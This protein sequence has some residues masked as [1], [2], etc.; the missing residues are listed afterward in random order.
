MKAFA[1]LALIFISSYSFAQN[2]LEGHSYGGCVVYHPLGHKIT[3]GSWVGDC[4]TGSAQGY[5]WFTYYFADNSAHSDYMEYKDGKPVNPY[6]FNSDP[7]NGNRILKTHSDFSRTVVKDCGQKPETA[8]AAIVMSAYE[9]LGDW[10]RINQKIKGSYNGPQTFPGIKR[11]FTSSG[12]ITP[13]NANFLIGSEGTKVSCD[14]KTLTD[15]INAGSKRFKINSSDPCE[16]QIE[17]GRSNYNYLTTLELSCPASNVSFRIARNNCHT[18]INNAVA[19]AKK[20]C[21]K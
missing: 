11:N 19:A 21:S 4:G 2:S 10:G 16:Q 20:A 18:K 7:V 6:V 14:T 13:P 3:R 9:E 15:I 1:A 12:G 8:C 17:I 5:G